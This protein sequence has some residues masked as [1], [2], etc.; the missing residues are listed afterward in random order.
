MRKDR[1]EYDSTTE[2]YSERRD[3][4]S[5][6]PTDMKRGKK[7]VAINVYRQIQPPCHVHDIS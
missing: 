2:R 6:N 1:T 3:E 4:Y 5:K 7:W